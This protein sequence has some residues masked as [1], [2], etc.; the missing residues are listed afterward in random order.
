MR[1]HGTLVFVFAVGVAL[2]V[3]ASL[4]WPDAG[5]AQSSKQ[6][7]EECRWDE[8]N[9]DGICHS[10]AICHQPHCPSAPLNPEPTP[11]GFRCFFPFHAHGGLCH[12]HCKNATLAWNPQ[13]STSGL[14]G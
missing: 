2:L 9:H 10:K 14:G 13:A 4:W 12:K 1:L 6:S 8:H 7:N 3:A 5:H 11:E